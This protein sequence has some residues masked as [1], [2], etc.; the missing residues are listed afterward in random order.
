MSK[1][2]AKQKPIPWRTIYTA[3]FLWLCLMIVLMRMFSEAYS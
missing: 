1:A 3:V 2:Y